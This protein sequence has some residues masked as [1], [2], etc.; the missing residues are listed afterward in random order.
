MIRNF[1]F[2]IFFYLGIILISI[3]FLPSLLL[4]KKIVLFGGKL[5][6]YWTGI[7]LKIFLSTKIIIKGKENLINKEK[8]F[9]ASS[10]QSM[11]ET[12]FLQTIFNSPIFILKKELLKIP[13]FGWYL[14]K[15]G[16]I[17]IDRGK[18]TKENLDFFKKISKSINESNRPLI[19]FPQGTRL[20]P[21][22]RT[23]FKKG[24]SRIYDELKI[25]CQ[26][27]AINSGSVWPKKDSLKP[28]LT[29]IIS[30]LKP[31]EAGMSKETFLEIL[32]KDIYTELD[33]LN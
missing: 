22:D 1:L 3:I 25:K 10:H 33:S 21:N 20:M 14:I 13:V 9:I 2:S 32:Q 8:F 24:V 30:I 28:N 12:F 17:S 4:P 16:S 5:M 26:P 7:C 29:L 31:I 11:F 27:V 23:Q 18:T 6:G 19:I 15:I